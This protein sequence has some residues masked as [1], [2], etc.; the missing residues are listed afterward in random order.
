M[1]FSL[2]KKNYAH[3]LYPHCTHKSVPHPPS[4]FVVGNAHFVTHKETTTEG[5]SS[6]QSPGFHRSN[7]TVSLRQFDDED[8]IHRV[9][10]RK[11][12]LRWRW[13]DVAGIGVGSDLRLQ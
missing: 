6:N 1:Y 12:M 13:P 3:K 9:S 8:M 2:F 10:S 11:F 7:V 5:N 4:R